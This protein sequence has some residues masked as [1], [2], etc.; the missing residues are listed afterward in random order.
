MPLQLSACQYKQLKHGKGKLHE[1]ICD[2]KSNN[3]FV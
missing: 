2:S 3:L 1:E